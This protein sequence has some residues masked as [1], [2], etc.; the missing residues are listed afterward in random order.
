MLV[1]SGMV[2]KGSE[3]AIAEFF[4]EGSCLKTEGIEECIRASALDRI[5]FRALHEL[6]AEA[7][8]SRRRRQGKGSDL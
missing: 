7:M 5:G 3:D 6:R 4:V 2:L 8:P 1:P